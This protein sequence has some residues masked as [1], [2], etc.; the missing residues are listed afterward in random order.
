M[1]VL[2]FL[3]SA[4]FILKSKFRNEGWDASSP[5][6]CVPIM[7]KGP[8]FN[9]HTT[10]TTPMPRNPDLVAHTFSPH[11]HDTMAGETEVQSHP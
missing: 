6:E 1:V 10:N 3:L 2:Q 5:V 4:K 11:T 8:F 7:Q 9:P